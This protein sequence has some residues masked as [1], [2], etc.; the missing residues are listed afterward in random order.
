L[1]AQLGAILITALYRVGRQADVLRAYQGLGT[2][3]GE[4]LGIGPSPGLHELERAVLNQDPT[5]EWQG[6]PPGTDGSIILAPARRVPGGSDGEATMAPAEEAALPW[7][8]PSERPPFVGRERELEAAMEA[9]SRAHPH[10][11]QGLLIITG[12]PGIGKT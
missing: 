2:P 4:E 9:R 3:L 10:G 7:L 1:R 12:E 8:A 11:Q 6:R 5:L